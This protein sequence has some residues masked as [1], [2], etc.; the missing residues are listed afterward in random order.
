MT[1]ADRPRLGPLAG[2][3]GVA[4]VSVVS[5]ITGLA[6]S[7]TSGDG[8]STL[9][10]WISELGEPG[11]SRFAA[12]FNVGLVVGGAAFAAFMTLLAASAAGRARYGWGLLGIGAGI[13][14][15]L[16][17]VF[18]MTTGREHVL[19]ALAFFGL[20]VLAIGAATIDLLRRGD[21]RFPR[22]LGVIAGFTVIAF[23]GFVVSLGIDPLMTDD[24][25]AAPPARPD[26]WSV[27]IL[28]WATLRGILAWTALAA[29]W[30]RRAR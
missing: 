6:Y 25:L 22:W 4:A 23:L 9:N 7:G 30:W 21:P 26:L 24:A 1:A 5:V 16:V 8:Y 10:H 19:A 27:P 12:V 3:L 14:G 2:L 18:P 29:W 17:G 13:A 11:V 28:E 20:G 15:L